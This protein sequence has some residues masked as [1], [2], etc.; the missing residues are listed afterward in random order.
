MIEERDSEA[1]E[2]ICAAFVGAEIDEIEIDGEEQT[3]TFWT[4]ADIA[5]EVGV[6]DGEIYIKMLTMQESVH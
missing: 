5:L 2:D 1:I 3:V 6:I 4:S